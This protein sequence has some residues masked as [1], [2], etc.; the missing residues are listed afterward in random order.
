MFSIGPFYLLIRN[1]P[2]I[3]SFFVKCLFLVMDL[4][5]KWERVSPPKFSFCPYKNLQLHFQSI[6]WTT[7]PTMRKTSCITHCRRMCLSWWRPELTLNSSVR[8]AGNGEDTEGDVGGCEREG[9]GMVQQAGN[10]LFLREVC[11]RHPS[12]FNFELCH[13]VAS[14]H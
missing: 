9:S 7:A 10:L 4:R 1:I 8:W 6:R 11:Q 13:L 3:T 5:G 12:H 14:I 2:Q